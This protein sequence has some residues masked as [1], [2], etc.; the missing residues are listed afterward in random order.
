[1]LVLAERLEDVP[2]WCTRVLV[3]PPGAVSVT[4][5]WLAAVTTA[6]A[7]PRAGATLPAAVPLAGLLGDLDHLERR[8]AAPPPG[9]AAV[10]GVDRA[11]PVEF[12][13]AAEGPHALVAGTT[14]AGKSELL[15]AWLLGLAVR[16]SP[17]DLQLV[18]VDYKG[19]A[20][21]DV[22][23]ALPHTAG[24]LTDLDPAATTRALASLRAEV[25]RRERVLAAAGA[26]DL[27]GYRAAAGGATAAGTAA[28]GAAVGSTAADHTGACVAPPR[29]LVVVDE[30]RAL[31]DTHPEVLSGLV[32]LAAQGRSLGIH[33]VLATQRPAGAVTPEI[34]ANLTARIC[35]RVLDAADSLDVLAVPDAARLPA[36]PGRALLRTAALR[37]I[38]V[39]WTGPHGALVAAV[40]AA[41]GSGW[42]RAGQGAAPARPWAEPLPAALTLTELPTPAADGSSGEGPL[43]FPLARTDLPDEQRL[44]VWTWDGAALLVA[45]GPRTGRTEALR[46]VVAQALRAGVAVHVLAAAP[47]RFADLRGPSLGTVVGADDPRRAAQLL[48]LL[49]AGRAGTTVLVVDDAD[50]VADRLD[51]TGPGR[52]VSALGALVRGASQAGLALALSGPPALV[53][54]RWTES[55]RT[56]LVL[57]PRDETE[58]LLAGVPA[59]LRAPHAG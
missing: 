47:E 48:H 7:T 9:L 58:S 56:R 49:A 20:T 14:G 30:F 41:T 40:L 54:A 43:A 35:L 17:A 38:Q 10:V 59:G 3:L 8:W 26:R 15:L 31:A 18:L 1:M 37:E 53:G 27:A 45:G 46:A 51:L 23:A 22:L 29:L 5:A 2:T 4:A 6:L 39:P 16:F 36:V 21:F 50:V 24:V 32:R 12:D 25:R 11:G 19:G 52:G 13:L 34:R 44:G 33:L 55:V 42:R 28:G 57:A